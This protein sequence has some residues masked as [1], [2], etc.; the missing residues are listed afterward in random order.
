MAS[1][2]PPLPIGRNIND[3]SAVAERDLVKSEVDKRLFI[4]LLFLIILIATGIVLFYV[5]NVRP[6]NEG[7]NTWTERFGALL[8]IFALT[9]DSQLKKTNEFL[10]RAAGR[11]PLGLFQPLSN[12]YR[13]IPKL[14]RVSLAFAIFGAIVWAY[15]SVIIYWFGVLST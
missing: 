4:I 7:I 11:I 13:F 10:F 1:R 8:G 6:P 3:P 5:P 15:G 9:I 14:E 2:P 12:S